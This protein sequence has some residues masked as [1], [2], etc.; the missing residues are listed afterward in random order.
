MYR[1]ATTHF[2]TDR[3]TKDGQTE[4]DDS[5]MPIADHILHQQYD[6]LKIKFISVV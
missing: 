1:L 6:P 2:A 3:R 4:T 5:I